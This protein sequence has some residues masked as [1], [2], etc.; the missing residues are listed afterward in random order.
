[1]PKQNHLIIAQIFIDDYTGGQYFIVSDGIAGKGKGID[2][3]QFI[4]ANSDIT[5]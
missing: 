3:D 2:A 4:I 1:M 5:A